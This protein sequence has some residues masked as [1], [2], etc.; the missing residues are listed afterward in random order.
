MTTVAQTDPTRPAWPTSPSAGWASGVDRLTSLPNGSPL[1]LVPKV[2]AGHGSRLAPRRPRH[3]PPTIRVAPPLEPLVGATCSAQE[4]T[5]YCNTCFSAPAPPAASAAACCDLC[6]AASADD[7]WCA[8]FDP[9][10]QTCYFKPRVNVSVPIMKDGVTAVWPAG[11]GPPPPLP[12]PGPQPSS[13]IENHGPYLHGSGMPAVDSVGVETP[14]PIVPDLYPAYDIGVQRNGT[15]T[16]EFGATAF[17]SFESLSA[18]LAPEHWSLHGGAAF[19]TCTPS[20]FFQKCA[21]GNVMGK[22]RTPNRPPPTD[23]RCLYIAL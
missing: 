8:V 3:V 22:S 14:P 6:A 16:S 18:T 11:R 17:S 10:D 19:D 1:G 7:C 21:G 15:F 13:S 4:N 20:N 9:D 5:D 12:P 2:S 23:T